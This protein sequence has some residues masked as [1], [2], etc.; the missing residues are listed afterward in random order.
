MTIPGAVREP[1]PGTHTRN[2][3]QDPRPGPLPRY[4]EARSHPIPKNRH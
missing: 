4:H 2:P 3:T 1:H